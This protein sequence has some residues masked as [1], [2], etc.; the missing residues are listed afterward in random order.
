MSASSIRKVPI[1]A[2]HQRFSQ[3]A[4]RDA[5]EDFTLALIRM[6]LALPCRECLSHAFTHADDGVELPLRGQAMVSLQVDPQSVGM[7]VTHPA[8]TE[9]HESNIPRPV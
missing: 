5:E 1:G 2:F 8:V 6:Q 4:G 9:L 7:R 3:P